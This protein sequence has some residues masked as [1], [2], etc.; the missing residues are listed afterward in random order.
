MRGM[1]R[2]PYP[3]GPWSSGDQGSFIGACSGTASTSYC[4]CALGDVM[5]QHPPS[6]KNLPGS[7]AVGGMTAADHTNDFP[8][9]AGK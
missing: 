4:N 9:C 2:F 6:T 1:P 7:I 5:Q 3:N 8:D